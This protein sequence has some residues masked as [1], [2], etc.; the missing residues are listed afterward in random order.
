MSTI[1]V[2]TCMYVWCVCV[3][4]CSPKSKRRL[5]PFKRVD[6]D[7]EKMQESRDK[8]EENLFEL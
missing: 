7:P 2:M 1:T 4:V 3:C 8:L 5:Q 6:L